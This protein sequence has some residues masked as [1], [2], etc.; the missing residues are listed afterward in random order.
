MSDSSEK[1]VR[2]EQILGL[3][4]LFLLLLG[5]LLV[6]WPFLTALAWAFILGF[7]LWP[8]HMRLT[9]ALKNRRTLSALLMTLMIALV[10]IAPIV[11]I[12]FNLAEDVTALRVTARQWLAS[13]T[14]TAPAWVERIPIIG[15]QVSSY[16]T[17]FAQ[18]SADVF[19]QMNRVPTTLPATTTSSDTVGNSRVMLFLRNSMDTLRSLFLTIGLAIGQGAIQLVLSVFLTFF[20]FR[21]GAAVGERLKTGIKR[22]AGQRG[23]HLLIVAGNTVR[24]VVYGILGTAI[25]QGIMAGIGFLIAGV[26]GAV[27]LGLLTF[28]LS[29]LPVG[30]PL[31]WIPVTILLFSEGTPGW[32]TFMLIWGLGVSSVDNIV[33]PWII[34]QGSDMPFILIFF[35][36]L[37]G[38]LAF[39]LIGVFL[40]P[41]LLAVCYR[42]IEE[43]SAS[44]KTKVA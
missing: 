41:T 24:G 11:V 6:L 20:I 12:G 1:P 7:C 19:Q 30:P 27:L 21:D 22:I 13:E 44:R 9:K 10:L 2:L 33:K 39:G 37:G 31:I 28:F 8:T 42:L 18:D 36:V 16:W 14:H 35:G 5:S 4:V 17:E 34:S 26:P 38:A 3:V 25:V 15:R 29:P 43:W 23:E 32:G 40:G